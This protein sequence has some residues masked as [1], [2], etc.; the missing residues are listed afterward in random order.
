MIFPLLSPFGKL[1]GFALDF[2]TIFRDFGGI[3]RE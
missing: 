1:E 3:L 2:S